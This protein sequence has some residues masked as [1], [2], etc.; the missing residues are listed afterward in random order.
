MSFNAKGIGAG[1][2]E[3]RIDFGKDGGRLVILGGGAERRRLDF[4]K[5]IDLD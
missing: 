3:Y 5:R 4:V 1:V 2:H